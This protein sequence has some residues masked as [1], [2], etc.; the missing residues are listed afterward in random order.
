MT[1]S[2]S[3][4][5]VLGVLLSEREKMLLLLA[6]GMCMFLSSLD[7][8]I[9]ATALPTILSDLGG[10]KL[11][12]WVF[13]LYMLTSTVVVPIIGKL[14]D[15][16]GRRPFVIS[17]VVIFLVGSLGC[18][19]A[20]TMIS[21]IVARS[22]Q[23]IGGGFILACVLVVMAD[24]YT[25]IERAKYVGYILAIITAGTL[26]GP[27]VGGFFADGP[28]WRWC[29]FINIPIGVVALATIW[30]TLPNTRQGGRIADIDFTGAAVLTTATV[31]GLLATAWAYQAY[32]WGSAITVGLLVAA[33]VLLLLFV[34]QELRHPNAIIPM[35][36][37]RNRMYV[38]TGLVAIGTSAV[39]FSTVIFLPT[40]VQTSL[41]ASASVS[42]LVTMPQAVGLVVMSFV[43]GQIVARTGRFKQ[44]VVVG[45]ALSGLA[46]FLLQLMGVGD[47]LWQV[48]VYMIIFG[49]GSG[50]VTP[51]I[52]VIV[53]AS[54]RQEDTGVATSS[55]MYFR[56]IAQVLGVAL[57]GVLFTT[58]YT[59]S[60]AGN[61]E[62]EVR[63]VM[64]AAVYE[65]LEG[66]ATL[67][68]DEERFESTRAEFLE[69][70][71][72]AALFD[73]AL[74]TQKEAVAVANKRIFLLSAIGGLVLV[75]ISLALTEIPLRGREPARTAEGDE[76]P[77]TVSASR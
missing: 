45:C 7:G 1:T 72:T 12:S 46:A 58:A 19:L 9:L 69:A 10:F 18:G 38:L 44:L 76:Q 51:L 8:A 13:T 17:G 39:L 21:L 65:E 42:G 11:L 20:P 37:F 4:E 16:F 32:G 73:R 15:M 63:A 3:S 26:L 64:P 53:Q 23:G 34:L 57:F 35:G 33:G 77:A 52:N 2:V 54:V 59:T 71:G 66:D 29:F 25:P 55:Q 60:F 50:F 40:F 14:S 5:P 41:G 62:Q 61:L 22:V 75:L 74:D 36:L 24:M 70:G 67:V 47:P 48:V 30:T 6:L 31:A 68:L 43:G 27:P 56:Q 28:G 49:M